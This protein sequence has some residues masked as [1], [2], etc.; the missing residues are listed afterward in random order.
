M[1]AYSDA[2]TVK[3]AGHLEWVAFYAV[4]SIR[5]DRQRATNFSNAITE[6]E[7]ASLLPYD[8][9]AISTRIA[10]L[11]AMQDEQSRQLQRDVAKATQQK[12]KQ[13]QAAKKAKLR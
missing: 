7:L 8:A 5:I 12:K 10:Q 4:W 3:R 11:R 13:A 1:K 6:K 9:A 2:D